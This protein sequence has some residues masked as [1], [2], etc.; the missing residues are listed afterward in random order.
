MALHAN[1]ASPVVP[2]QTVQIASP[3]ISSRLTRCGDVNYM[4]GL[5]ILIVTTD[6]REVRNRR[7][8]YMEGRKQSASPV[9]WLEG[10]VR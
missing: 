3:V 5:S 7:W 2:G 8:R 10:M 1:R 6:E 9:T 4:P